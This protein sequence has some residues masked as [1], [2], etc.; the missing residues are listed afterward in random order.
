MGMDLPW[1]AAVQASPEQEYLVLLSFLPLKQSR[2]LPRFVLYTW[3][4]LQQL[5]STRG[6][7]GYT[8]R[9]QLLAK[10]FW[11]LSAWESEAAMRAFVQA[12]PHRE[13]MAALA[14]YMGQTSFKRWTVKGAEL[15]LLWDDA[16]RR[17]RKPEAG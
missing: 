3:R 11:T 8:L 14:P 12:P 7:I 13:I 16:L 2:G 9:A 17:S 15:P 1:R 5:K 4:V 10:S 6:L